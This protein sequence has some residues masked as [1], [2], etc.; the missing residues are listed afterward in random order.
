MFLGRRACLVAQGLD[1]VVVVMFK[2]VSTMVLP[3]MGKACTTLK[4]EKFLSPR[5]MLPES[6]S[7]LKMKLISHPQYTNKTH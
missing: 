3:L 7:L 5:D 4:G 6:A 1:A 2:L